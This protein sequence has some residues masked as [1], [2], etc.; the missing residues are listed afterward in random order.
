MPTSSRTLLERL[1]QARRLGRGQ[2]GR[3]LHLLVEQ[4]LEQGQLLYT[5]G[6]PPRQMALLLSGTLLVT[7]QSPDGTQLPL[8]RVRPGEVIG[9]MGMLDGAPRSATVRCE[10]PAALLTMDRGRYDLLLS[11]ADPVLVWL[12]E[13]AARGMAKRIGAMNERLAAAATDPDQLRSLPGV[14]R[15]RPQRFWAWLVGAG[16]S[17]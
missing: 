8:G 7:A 1:P 12:L 4:R 9:E 5:Q 14:A 10:Q 17:P 2:R 15:Q 16:K 11:Q 6:D 3:V 13:I